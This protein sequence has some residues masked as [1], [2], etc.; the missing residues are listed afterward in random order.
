ML[1]CP[2]IVVLVLSKMWA[3]RVHVSLLGSHPDYDAYG[4]GFEVDNHS[5]S[6]TSLICGNILANSPLRI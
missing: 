5:A 3:N 1:H 6:S 2:S 4:W